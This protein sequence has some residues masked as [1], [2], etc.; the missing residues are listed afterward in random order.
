MSNGSQTPKHTPLGLFI[1]RT[2]TIWCTEI[3][4]LI[5]WSKMKSSGAHGLQLFN[6][7][8]SKLLLNTIL[9]SSNY[10]QVLQI[11]SLQILSKLSFWGRGLS[12]RLADVQRRIY[13]KG[14]SLHFQSINECNVQ[15]AAKSDSYSTDY[16]CVMICSEFY[17][18]CPNIC[19]SLFQLLLLTHLLRSVTSHSTCCFS[20]LAFL[21]IFP[22]L[23]SP[24]FTSVKRC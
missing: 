23:P 10:N 21:S 14:F 24:L 6:K 9:N 16:F 19:V 7:T 1:R 17:K 20:S 4:C 18:V 3:H 12:S 2:N 5:L 11:L 8:C 22:S 15:Y 13:S